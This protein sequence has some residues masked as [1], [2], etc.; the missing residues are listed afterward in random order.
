[1]HIQSQKMQENDNFVSYNPNSNFKEFWCIKNMA[2]LHTY[3]T[4]Y[5]C[6]HRIV[7]AMV[8]FRGITTRSAIDYYYSQLSRSRAWA[9]MR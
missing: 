8:L 6:E 3:L 5:T 9:I 2:T 4:R 7:Y 1:M